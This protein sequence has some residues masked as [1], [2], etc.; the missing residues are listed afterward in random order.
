MPYALRFTTFVLVL[1]GVLSTC[2]A[3][4]VQAETEGEIALEMRRSLA[5]D[6]L[7]GAREALIRWL[8]LRPGDSRLHY[9]M[10]CLSSRLGDLESAVESLRQAFALGFDDL[11]LVAD[12]PDLIALHTDD[13]FLDLLRTTG[14][15]LA[16]AADRRTRNLI[17]GQILTLPL[18]DSDG[19]PAEDID[20]NLTVDHRGFHLHVAAR[21]ELFRDDPAPWVTGGGVEWTLTAP[22][23][24]DIYDTRRS[25]RF[26]FGIRNGLPVGVVIA[27]P[28]HAIDQ[29]VLE[30][31]PR[32][33]R[34]PESDIR[35]MTV[36]VP[37]TYLTPYAPPADTLYG[38]NLR[39]VTAAGHRSGSPALIADPAFMRPASQHRRFV[40]IV[41]SPALDGPA[42]LSGR[43]R[44]TI[45]GRRPLLF[46]LVAWMPVPTTA[47]LMTN[48]L[49]N[50]GRSVVTSGGGS[51]TV[52]LPRGATTMTRGADLSALPDGPYHLRSR[53]ELEDGR[54]MEWRTGLFRF[55]GDWIHRTTDR[56]KPLSDA[57][58][59][60]VEWRMELISTALVERDPRSSPAPLITT[61]A[62]VD[63]LLDAFEQTGLV[64]PAQGDIVV[65]VPGDLG[66]RTVN[67][68]LDPGWNTAGDDLVVLVLASP[69]A[70][71]LRSFLVERS[72]LSTRPVV[73]AAPTPGEGD[74]DAVLDA[75]HRWIAEVFPQ[76]QAMTAGGVD[77]DLPVRPF[78]NIGE[79]TPAEEAERLLGG[80]PAIR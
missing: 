58:R 61:V 37:W 73:I 21:A 72:S 11:R 38:V 67:L 36:T 60:S 49:D 50:A 33:D 43:V 5:N 34:D 16:L 75:L 74:F 53:L 22:D 71:G 35:T 3:I 29:H 55:G 64:L 52:A 42:R 1:A 12:D 80:I 15:S 41:V 2:P 31:A 8:D 59:P 7:V 77:S 44:S 69:S 19:C 47:T 20:A 70:L 25:W 65:M 48:V 17:E 27:T 32:I 6:D 66:S 68:H 9:N 46:D 14:A 26:G 57:M 18:H 10:G 79:I 30:L 51:E 4:T 28:E 13:D 78:G 76:A 56:L 63:R 40:R 54:A 24:D 45:V 39:F 62:E 23:G